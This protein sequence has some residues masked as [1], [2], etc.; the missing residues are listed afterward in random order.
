M[1]MRPSARLSL[2]PT[3]V[4]SSLFA[5]TGCDDN[6]APKAGK[7]GASASKDGKDGKGDKED[8]G[9]KPAKTDDSAKGEPAKKPAKKSG[10][11][12]KYCVDGVP[13][14]D[15]CVAKEKA[16]S[17]PK[18]GCAC[19]GSERKQPK[20]KQGQRVKGLI[21]ADVYAYNKAQG[22]PIEGPFT[23]EQAFEGDDQLANSEGG[24]L[25]ATF[26]TDMGEFDCKLF[27]DKAPLTVANFV[28]L[29]RG[30]RPVYEKK[31][32]KW[33]KRPFYDGVVF[34]RVIPNFMIQTGDPLGS[35]TGGPGYFIVDEFDSSLRHTSAGI[36][37]MA[38]RNAVD[39]RTKKL[40][41]DPKTGQAIGNTGSSQFFVTVNKT[42]HL[43]DRH[44]IFGKCANAKVAKKISEVPTKSMPKFGIQDRPVKD[45]RVKT[46]KITRK[47]KK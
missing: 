34:H 5:L 39:P 2:I 32:K 35:G 13:D 43:D 18:D 9:A 30:T 33:I 14:G 4:L 28:G 31:D 44:T 42:P 3:V 17:E 7:A 47:P 23:L 29:A 10:D 26:V 36:L 19:P 41:P 37:S 38:N 21:A 16:P 22:D 45:V 12:C 20:F 25:I 11:C 27:E 46:I 24:D 40:R 8:A 1:T 6:S 15:E